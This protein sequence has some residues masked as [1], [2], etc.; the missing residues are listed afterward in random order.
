ME[1]FLSM[2]C[3]DRAFMRKQARKSPEYFDFD[4]DAILV[5]FTDNL[6]KILRNFGDGQSWPD[7][8]PAA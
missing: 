1:I 5:T 2:A 6:V 7:F 8:R 3:A 4:G